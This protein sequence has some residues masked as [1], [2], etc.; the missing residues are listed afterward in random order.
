M[1]VGGSPPND[2]GSEM[3]FTFAATAGDVEQITIDTA[4]LTGGTHTMST[5][6]IGKD[7]WISRS[8]NT[9]DDAISGITLSLHDTTEDGEGGYNNI[10]VNLTRDTEALKEKVNGLVE[11]YNATVMFIDENTEYDA[12]EKVAGILSNEY[13]VNAIERAMK[14]PL[15]G[16]VTGFDSGDP[17][18]MPSDIGLTF[19]SDGLL[20]LDESEFDEAIVDDY[21]GVLSLIGAMKSGKSDRTDIKFYGAGTSTTAGE[22]EVEVFGDGSSITSARIRLVGDATWR[23][24]TIDGNIVMGDSSSNATTGKPN[25]PEYNLQITVDESKTLPGGVTAIIN[26][27]QGFAG[28]V[29]DV[30]KDILDSTTGSVPISLESVDSKI[31]NVNDRIEAEEARRVKVEHRLIEKFAR[32]ERT[33]TLI[34]QQMGALNM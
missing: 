27:K 15:S 23:D 17:F 28:A 12:E 25:Y 22:Y 33:L 20:E 11:A 3:T 2:S 26:V 6:T 19:D 21:L 13:F 30:L 32:L 4:S 29:E 14:D 5:Q 34:Q 1:T 10:E 18:T 16:I 24:A 31:E 7:G 9:I 8:T